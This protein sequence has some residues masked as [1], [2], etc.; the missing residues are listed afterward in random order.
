MNILSIGTDREIMNQESDV[1]A[2]MLLYG[3]LVENYHIHC[4][5]SVELTNKEISSNIWLHSCKSWL[6]SLLV[7][8]KIVKENN[9]DVIISP[10]PFAK[11]W[12]CMFFAF[13]F[14]KKFLL[15][16]YG[17]NIFDE[18]W[19][20]LSVLNRLYSWI[21]RIVFKYAD[22]IQTDGLETY[23]ELKKK[24]GDKVFWKPMVPVNIN[25]LLEIKRDSQTVNE[26]PKV[27]YVGRLIE[28]KNIPFL[29]R[30]IDAI[31]DKALVTVIGEGVMKKLLP[32]NNKDIIYIAK[33]S[34]YEI[35]ESFRNADIFVL[36]SYFE[37][38]ARVIMEAAL[39]GVPVIT[40]RVSGIQG[41]M[42]NDVS[43]YVFE[44]GDEI[45]FIQ[46]LEELVLNSQKR[47]IMGENIREKARN[48]LST[49]IM[50]TKQKV[51][52]DY[53]KSK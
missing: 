5:S 48:M 25:E 7:L 22:A 29:A 9:I 24:Y 13:I 52:F 2:R 6:K 30:V 3:P 51:V 37:G 42:E 14:K 4:V 20:R 33:Q 26:K 17:G 36:T 45:G 43:G 1:H 41:I 38:F 53:L 46:T 32:L 10:D 34:R 27:L 47:K 44:Q 40:T 31:K 49:E 19:K 18:N 28:Q 39:A 21:G 11:A 8:R 35:V 23:N 12:V 16:V 15:S 50:L